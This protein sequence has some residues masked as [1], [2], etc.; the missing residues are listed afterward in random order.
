MVREVDKTLVRKT[1]Q[2]EGPAT[3]Q[4]E[5]WGCSYPR[6]DSTSGTGSGASESPWTSFCLGVRIFRAKYPCIQDAPPPTQALSI[7]AR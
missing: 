4:G 7:G 1:D 6:A 2:R 3:S 5:S